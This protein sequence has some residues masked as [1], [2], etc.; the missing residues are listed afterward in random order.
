MVS[1]PKG[2]KCP[3]CGKAQFSEISTGSLVRCIYCGKAH[4]IDL[5]WWLSDTQHEDY[6]FRLREALK[7][8]KVTQVQFARMVG[9]SPSHI[10]TVFNGRN[11]YISKRIW[12]VARRY[13]SYP[14]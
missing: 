14:S 10:N 9:C 4:H 6:I 7:R 3:D 11:H 1:L 8:S 13:V 2:A 12:E 5:Y